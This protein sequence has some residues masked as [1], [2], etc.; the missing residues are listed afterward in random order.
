[1]SAF[2]SLHEKVRRWIW[3]QGWESLREV[4][5]RS[6]PVLL[7]GERDLIIMAATAGGKTEAA[8]LPIVSRL[9]SEPANPQ[10][11][12]QAIYVSPMRALINDQFG[13]M[14]SLCAELDVAVTK[15]HGDVAASVKAKARNNPNGILLITPE[16]LEALLVRRGKEVGRIFKGLRYVVIDEMHVFLGDPRGKQLQ[17]VLHRMDLASASRPVR[18]GLSATLANETAA[19]LFLRPLDPS[20]V[21][22]LPPAA[23]APSIKLQLRGYIRPVRFKPSARKRGEDADRPESESDPAEQQLVQHLCDTHR[24]ARSLIF[25]GSRGEVEAT[26]VRLSEM[27][28]A[29]GVPNAFVAHHGSLSREHREYAERRMKDRSRPASIVCTTTLELGIDVGDIEAVAQVGPGHTVSGMR[30]RLGRSGRR[31]GEAAVMRVYVTE[32][33]LTS[34]SHPLDALRSQT[35]QAIAMLNLMVLKW[36]EPP[37]PERLHLSTLLHQVMAVISQLGG[38]TPTE[39]WDILIKSA[40]FTGIDVALFKR[41]LRRMLDPEVGLLERA[42]DQTLLPGPNGERLIESRDIFAVFLSSEDYK[43]IAQGGRAIGQIPSDNPF[44]PGQLMVLAGRRWRIQEVDDKRRELIVCPASGG[45]P[46]R[47]NSNRE[48]PSDGVMDEMRRVFTDFD[49]PIYLDVRAKQLLVEARTTFDRLGLRHSNVARHDGQLLLF[50]WVG[51]RRQQALLLALGEAELDPAT[52]GLAITVPVEHEEALTM[53]LKRLAQDPPPD[54]LKLAEAVQNKLTEKFDMF[55]GNELLD[56]AWARDR[57]DTSAIPKLAGTLLRSLQ[58]YGNME[59][60][61]TFTD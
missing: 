45:T 7:R 36:N 30:Q 55:L 39:L 11:G 56:M 6:I 48:A 9:A 53:E 25:A 40:V 20:R 51:G 38:A 22:V 42:T 5:E 13:R 28:E 44:V 16:S 49:L 12:F 33:E 58:A 32:A 59:T 1:M 47:F 14:E 46:P 50:P 26:T 43:V 3:Q 4:Q 15:W 8:F 17:S 24:L 35:V 31:P 34:S 18:I 41:L 29:L 23:S 60:L 19:R 52:L 54:G 2:D 27:T 37:D 57:L 61:P 10:D 21:D